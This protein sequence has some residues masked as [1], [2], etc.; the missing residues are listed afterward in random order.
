MRL[1]D[2]SQSDFPARSHLLFP[3]IAFL[4]GL[5]FYVFPDRFPQPAY[6]VIPIIAMIL[7]FEHFRPGRLRFVS[8]DRQILISLVLFVLYTIIVPLIWFL[9][10]G[11]AQMLFYPAFYL[12]NLLIFWV[13][14]SLRAVHGG[15]FDVVTE[16]SIVVALVLQL[17]LLPLVGSQGELRQSL[18]FN[19]PNQLGYYALL[20]ST[21]I[22]LLHERSGIAK[23]WVLIGSGGAFVLGVLSLSRSA[24]S[25]MVLLFLL[26]GRHRPRRLLVMG[27]TIGLAVLVTWISLPQLARERLF[28]RTRGSTDSLAGRGYDRMINHPEFLLFGAAEGG[29]DRFESAQPGEIHSSF[30]TILFAY[31]LPG[32]IFFALFLV[33]VLRRSGGTSWMLLAPALVYGLTHQGLRFVMFWVFLGLVCTPAMQGKIRAR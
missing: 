31:G 22:L 30:G 24:L 18:F 12:F 1:S 15:Y 33:M 3:W 6:L 19:N 9:W 5:P 16:K 21:A 2:D 23:R 20:S 13:V 10:L 25:S 27:A 28:L 8:D 32:L 17:V 14:L 26:A 4:L 11:N 29:F 7:Y